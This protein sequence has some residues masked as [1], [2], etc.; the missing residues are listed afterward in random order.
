MIPF[1]TKPPKTLRAVIYARVSTKEQA[2]RGLSIST[3]I[4]NCERYALQQ[5]WKLLEPYVDAG[6]SGTDPFT[7]PRFREMIEASLSAKPPFEV[8]LAARADRFGRS[9]LDGFIKKQVR[10]NG[11]RLI[12]LDSPEGNDESAEMYE[13]FNE[14]VA[15]QYPRKLRTQVIDGQREAVKQGRF[16]TGIAFAPFGYRIDARLASNNRLNKQLVVDL[17]T[18]P[19]LLSIFERYA[20]GSSIRSIGKWLD[21]L[22]KSP[23]SLAGRKPRGKT[24]GKWLG[25]TVL[26]ILRN[27]VYL[28]RI[29]YGRRSTKTVLRRTREFRTDRATW[30]VFENAHVP[31]VSQDLFDRVQVR[32][33]QQKQYKARTDHPVNFLGSFGRCMGCGATAALERNGRSWYFYCRSWRRFKL[34][35]VECRRAVRFE[36]VALQVSLW[37]AALLRPPKLIGIP[38]ATE[39][40]QFSEDNDPN[41][42]KFAVFHFDENGHFISPANNA[43]EC[44]VKRYNEALAHM[45][46]FEMLPLNRELATLTSQQNNLVTAIANGADS[47]AICS[48]LDDIEKRINEINGDIREV[49]A[50][51]S[52]R[53]KALD[54]D[55]LVRNAVEMSKALL[56]NDAERLRN[57]IPSIF[58]NVFVNFAYDE[59]AERRRAKEGG[60]EFNGSGSIT[61]RARYDLSNLSSVPDDALKMLA[62]SASRGALPKNHPRSAWQEIEA[63]LD[64]SGA[65]SFD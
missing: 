39:P 56:E 47:S 11:V 65:Q 58:S 35:N 3:Q 10:A 23:A 6:F 4:A 53:F 37:V 12:C 18:G 14:L 45:P 61:L 41:N 22:L 19:I 27:E 50:E 33:S 34:G 40:P 32:L 15:R 44:A 48:K 26:R 30:S 55:D 64:F 59:R 49:E 16:G 7:R 1:G 36:T 43:I 24:H 46:D 60:F 20:N 54:P 25:G 5:G 17:Q 51:M 2:D 57:L 31:L 21:S 9:D 42:T 52:T 62:Q 38:S 13:G 29:I 28:G 8:I 63:A